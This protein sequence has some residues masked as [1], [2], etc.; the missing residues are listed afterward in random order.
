MLHINDNS[1]PHIFHVDVFVQLM[2]I[3][4]MS[5]TID[6]LWVMQR[7]GSSDASGWTSMDE[8]QKKQNGRPVTWVGGGGLDIKYVSAIL[9][10]FYVRVASCICLQQL[11][12][13]RT[14]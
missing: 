2:I 3:W 14:H 8:E 12:C 10:D 5:K 1:T 6:T 9:L 13:P 4:L 11:S 7:S